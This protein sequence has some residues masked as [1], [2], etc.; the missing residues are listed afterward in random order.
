MAGQS[1]L[2]PTDPRVANAAT[3]DG[4]PLVRSTSSFVVCLYSHLYRL[5]LAVP[6]S[7]SGSFTNSRRHASWLV[8][9]RSCLSL[10]SPCFAPHT[11]SVFPAGQPTHVLYSYLHTDFVRHHLFAVSDFELQASCEKSLARLEGGRSPT[12]K[13]FVR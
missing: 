1:F 4:K 13:G 8:L 11:S 10:S 9:A 7:H 12:G 6:S 5:H 3:A 2:D